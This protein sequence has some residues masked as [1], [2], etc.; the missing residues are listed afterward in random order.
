MRPWCGPVARSGLF[1]LV[2]A[3]LV[4]E[5]LCVAFTAVGSPL[6]VAAYY[7]AGLIGAV[8]LAWILF[9]TWAFR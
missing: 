5:G 2:V 1:A 8:L 3:A 9:W 4:D 6:A 7:A